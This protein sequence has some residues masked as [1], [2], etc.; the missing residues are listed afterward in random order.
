[1]A[2]LSKGIPPNKREMMEAL[3]MPESATSWHSGQELQWSF[4]SWYTP[5]QKNKTKQKETGPGP[6]SSWALDGRPLG[7]REPVGAQLTYGLEGPVAG[8]GDHRSEGP[9]RLSTV[10]P[11]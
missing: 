2:T 5:G 9:A 11:R 4:V 8:K 10:S 6:V 7:R 3:G 1:M